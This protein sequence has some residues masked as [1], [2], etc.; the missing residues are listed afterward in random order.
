MKEMLT[1]N[2]NF[3]CDECGKFITLEDLVEGKALHALV[4][5]DSHWSSEEYLTLCREHYDV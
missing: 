1:K 3:K 5:P 4:T 2:N